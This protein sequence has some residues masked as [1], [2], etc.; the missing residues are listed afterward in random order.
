[1]TVNFFGE[2]TGRQFE[3]KSSAAVFMLKTAWWNLSTRLASLSL[4]TTDA[5]G[6]GVSR[7]SGTDKGVFSFPPRFRYRCDTKVAV[8]QILLA[9]TGMFNEMT[10][11]T[12][13]ET[14]TQ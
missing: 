9:D 7:A 13:L 10:F 1:M 4:Q 14:L 2:V 12:L 3:V 6:E 8:S 5:V 11:I